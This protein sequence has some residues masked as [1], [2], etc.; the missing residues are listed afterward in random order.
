MLDLNYH[1]DSASHSCYF[2]PFRAFVTLCRPDHSQNHL[3]KRYFVIHIFALNN[4]TAN[5]AKIAKVPFKWLGC[6]T[7]VLQNSKNQK[8][9]KTLIRRLGRTT[10]QQ[11]QN[12]KQKSNNSH[13]VAGLTDPGLANRFQLGEEPQVGLLVKI[14]PVSTTTLSNFLFFE[15][16]F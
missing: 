14:L 10:K 16:N 1:L 9:A 5:L 6:I 2:L 4:N 11:K 13:H 3:R 15:N 12:I 7:Q 8:K